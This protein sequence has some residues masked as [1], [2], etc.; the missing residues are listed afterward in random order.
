MAGEDYSHL[1]DR[2]QRSAAEAA[3]KSGEAVDARGQALGNIVSKFENPHDALAYLSNSTRDISKRIGELEG[4]KTKGDLSTIKQ[5][6]YDLLKAQRQANASL[7]AD[8]IKGIMGAA[9]AR[10]QTYRTQD[11]AS[12]ETTV[13]SLQNSLASADKALADA[14]GKVKPDKTEIAAFAE[15]RASAERRFNEAKQIYDSRKA[16][17]DKKKATE[18][19]KTVA[20]EQKTEAEKSEARKATF[21]NMDVDDLEGT[22]GD[23]KSSANR[24][25]AR[26]NTARAADP[27]SEETKALQKEFDQ[28][29]LKYT[30]ATDILTRKRI[31]KEE[32]DRK[33]QDKTNED[34]VRKQKTQTELEAR[35]FN[36]K[37]DID[38]LQIDIE[39]LKNDLAPGNTLSPA[40]R[41]K[42]QRELRDKTA[43]LHGL[44]DRYTADSSRVDELKAKTGVTDEAFRKMDKPE[45]AKEL[46]KIGDEIED[47]YAYN[48]ADIERRLVTG[49]GK[50]SKE[51]MAAWARETAD[52]I[53]HGGKKGVDMKNLYR[54]GGHRE[55]VITA[56][57]S[58]VTSSERIN[59]AL[60]E[61]F[62]TN[63][64]K[65][66]DF[67][68][69]NWKWG[70]LLVLLGIVLAAGPVT[71]TVFAAKQAIR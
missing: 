58:R 62:P 51:E 3:E 23:L 52:K 38:N 1:L 7:N 40:D 11:F 20:D 47:I 4:S 68:K 8:V 66:M 5:N 57:M 12:L 28:A 70:V 6:E 59:A 55:E 50:V 33:N 2:Q 15:A 45:R 37:S 42:K 14:K 69:K 46:V 21:R 22:V 63:F 65:V 71:A 41:D 60:K 29:T 18:Q 13:T 10:M 17:E 53:I 48:I 43:Q 44:Q 27:T 54:I 16:E 30:E 64:D 32:E 19:A 61:K 31:E 39:D 35:M 9:E 67:A 56:M 49:S 24:I 34:F 26:L 25:K 36:D